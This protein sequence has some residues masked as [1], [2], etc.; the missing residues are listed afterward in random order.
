MKSFICKPISLSSLRCSSYIFNHRSMYSWLWLLMV[1][2]LLA[3]PVVLCQEKKD[4]IKDDVGVDMVDDIIYVTPTIPHSSSIY[5]AEHFDNPASFKKK[6]VK[7]EAKKEGIEDDIAKY[8][9]VWDIEASE[10]DPL[11]GDLGLVLK[12]KAKHSAIAAKLDRPF[13]FDEKPFVVQY[14]VNMQ[15]GQECGGAYLKLLSQEKASNDLRQFHDKTP[16]SIM[17]GPDKCGS[18]YK[19]HFIFRHKNPIN[20]TISEKHC[21][22]PKERIE[23]PFTDK[24]PHL[25]TLIV[26]P[27]NTFHVYVDHK[28]V[29]EGSLLED[30]TPPVNPPEEIDDPSD[31]RPA[32][33]D[34]RERIPDATATKPDDW[35]EDAPQYIPDPEAIKP[36]GWLDDE[37][38]NVPDPSA[39]KP[40]DWDEDIDGEWEAPLIS[41]PACE[42]APGCGAW[43]PPEILNPEYKGKWRP[44][45]VDNP[46]Y[47]GKW[48]P[49]RIP[50][51]DYFEDRD[52]FRMTSIVAVGLELWSMSNQIMFDNILITDDP[53]L[54]D[55]WAAQT[56]DVKKKKMEKVADSLLT[57]LLKYTNEHPWLWAIYI[58]VIAL[59]IVLVL[60]FCCGSSKE[61][62]DNQAKKS[63]DAKKT[64]AFTPDDPGVQEDDVDVD[65]EGDD[66][67]IE[68]STAA[69]QT[70]TTS[71]TQNPPQK[72]TEQV[73]EN[74]EQED[75]DDEQEEQEEAVS[76]GAGDAP[77][78]PRKRR[79]RKD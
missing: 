5:I 55:A 11:K 17:F 2:L 70:S 41:N 28:V 21:K 40:A 39:E 79:P 6:W 54:A 36:V 34:D 32:D 46:N 27:D 22:K 18:D 3:L 38:Q 16:Y 1:Y 8:D 7:S 63:E 64:D 19:L 66:E 30:F 48:A 33:W 29:N 25:Y 58:V 62:E 56:F 14:E 77:S 59:P 53:A 15:S 37:P 23:E 51:P 10:I 49:R 68:E 50:N 4:E 52:P 35:D 67:G 43:T 69:T 45:L 73:S 75:D 74:E 76:I 61:K 13:V 12:S 47:Q 60:A 57:A 31:V 65:N 42:E 72:A 71:Q 78:S 44:P 9:G 20:G 24:R 26:R